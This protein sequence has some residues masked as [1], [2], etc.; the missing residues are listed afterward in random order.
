MSVTKKI[1][2]PHGAIT[3]VSNHSG[4]GRDYVA[5]FA[6]DPSTFKGSATAAAKILEGIEAFKKNEAT[7]KAEN[8]KRLN[9][10]LATSKE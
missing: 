2:L 9:R 10:L 6:K 8:D 5:E 1:A 7:I 3:W 4:Y